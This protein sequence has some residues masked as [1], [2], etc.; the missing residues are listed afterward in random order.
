MGTELHQISA[1]IQ[2]SLA[3]EALLTPQRS[4]R[5]IMMTQEKEMS[6]PGR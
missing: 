6:C 3:A 2:A 1:R 5:R 4:Q